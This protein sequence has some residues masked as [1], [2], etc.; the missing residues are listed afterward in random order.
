MTLAH[1]KL[2]EWTQPGNWLDASETRFCSRVIDLHRPPP[3]FAFR[4]QPCLAAAGQYFSGIGLLG[5]ADDEGVRLNGGRPGAALGPDAV[6]AELGRY[7]AAESVALTDFD[8]PVFD[9]GNIKPGDS[10][11]ETHE[12]VTSTV[13]AMLEAGL[14]PVGIGGGH[15]LSFPELRAVIDTMTHPC[16]LTLDGVYFD[17]HLDVRDKPGSGMAFRC[18]I[19]HGGVGA[20]R[21]FGLDPLANTG[22]HLDWFLDH[23]G[24]LADWPPHQWPSTQACFVSICL[25][26]IDMAEAPGVSAPAPFGMPARRIAEYAEAAGRNP[27]VCCFDIMELSP[28]HDEHGRTARLAAALLLRFFAGLNQRPA[29]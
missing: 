8:I 7:G 21:L 13:T 5:L 25:D 20:L 1:P 11:G 24:E 19:E 18:L 22:T 10:L 12:R 26:V 23:H 29:P 14:M 3:D 16:G 17:A 15:D 27:S 28:P 6:R 9:L 4:Q 2:L